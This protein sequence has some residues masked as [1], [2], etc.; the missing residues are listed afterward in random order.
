MTKEQRP[1]L[2]AL[3]KYGQDTP[4]AD[5]Y[6]PSALTAAVPSRTPDPP[7]EPDEAMADRRDDDTEAGLEDRLL[8]HELRTQRVRRRARDILDAERRGPLPPFDAGTLAE[9]LARPQPPPSRVDGLIPSEAGTLVVA[10]RKLGKTTLDLNLAP[11]ADHWRDLPRPL[12]SPSH[13]WRGGD[14]QLRGLR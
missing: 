8:V 2:A 11:I 13:Q 1:E 4:P 5:R 14:S 6:I 9:M 12:C 10:Q 7:S 3:A